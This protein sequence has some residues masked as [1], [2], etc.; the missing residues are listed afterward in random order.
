MQAQSGTR[1]Q[2]ATTASVTD[3]TAG[4][5]AQ[6]AAMKEKIDLIVSKSPT[7]SA[8]KSWADVVEEEA[9][10][11]THVK[12]HSIWDEFDISKISN[13]GF[14]LEYVAPTMLVA[15]PLLKLTWL[16]LAQEIAY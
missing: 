10:A 5:Q 7:S 8:K 11:T 15:P 14:K 16:I 2:R 13:V 6:W 3:L 9:N 12:K 1:N 4:A